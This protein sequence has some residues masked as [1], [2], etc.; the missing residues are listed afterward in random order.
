M[1]NYNE[2]CEK[3]FREYTDSPFMALRKMGSV[4]GQYDR[5]WP[6]SDMQSSEV[7]IHEDLTNGFRDIHGKVYLVPYVNQ[8]L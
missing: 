8:A 5:R 4:T 3:R 7:E 1:S 6:I 2:M